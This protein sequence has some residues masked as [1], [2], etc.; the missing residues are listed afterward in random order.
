MFL[1]LLKRY[2]TKNEF[3]VEVFSK[4]MVINMKSSPGSHLNLVIFSRIHTHLLSLMEYPCSS[5][6]LSHVEKGLY[7][8][9]LFALLNKT[10]E[11]SR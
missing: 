8:T 2:K 4:W 3:A 6:N 10:I 5:N 1:E 11:S 9:Q 7:F